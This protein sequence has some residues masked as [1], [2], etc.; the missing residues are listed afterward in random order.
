MTS[1]SAEQHHAAVNFIFRRMGCVRKTGEVLRALEYGMTQS[2]KA[3]ERSGHYS[4][5]ARI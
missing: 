4:P 1:P 2:R 3:F 5:V